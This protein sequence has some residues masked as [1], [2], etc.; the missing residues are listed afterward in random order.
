MWRYNGTP[1]KTLSLPAWLR[2]LIWEFAVGMVFDRMTL[3]FKRVTFELSCDNQIPSGTFIQEYS[4]N[5]MIL[6]HAVLQIFCS[7]GHL[8]YLSLK[9]GL[10]QSKFDRILWKVN[11]VIYIMYTTVSWYHD[12]SSSGSADILFTRLLYYTKCQSRKRR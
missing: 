11:Q 12:P 6:A 3:Y 8:W 10:I 7:Q 5:I 2:M 4:T 9:R 1:M